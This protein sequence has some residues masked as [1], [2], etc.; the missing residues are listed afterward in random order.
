MQVIRDFDPDSVFCLR[1]N[2]NQ[3]H[4][5]KNKL[6]TL[7][8]LL[9]NRLGNYLFK[10]NRL[11]NFKMCRCLFFTQIRP[12]FTRFCPR[13]NRQVSVKRSLIEKLSTR[14]GLHVLTALVT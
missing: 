2:T 11:C 4:V 5:F 1:K 12:C 9:G 7:E 13:L 8:K 3:S 10:I 6:N 14:V